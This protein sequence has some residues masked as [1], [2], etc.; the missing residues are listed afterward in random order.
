MGT[1]F[2]RTV[3]TF[4]SVGGGGGGSFLAHAAVARTAAAKA[5]EV[6]FVTC[7]SPLNGPTLWVSSGESLSPG[8]PERRQ[9]R[10]RPPRRG[11]RDAT[12]GVCA[13]AVEGLARRLAEQPLVV[14]GEPP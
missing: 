9:E 12:S 3:A 14:L 5:I 4:T 11:G 8:H 2:C 1:S 6:F 10:R 13:A 7:V